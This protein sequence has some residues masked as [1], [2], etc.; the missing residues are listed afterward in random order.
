MCGIVGLAQGQGKV[1]VSLYEALLM[2]QHRGQDAAGM[3]TLKNGRFYERKKNGLVAD[4]FAERHFDKLK[5]ALGLGHVRYPT[6]GTESAR[7]AQPFFANA[8]FG[9]FL[10]HNGNLTNTDDLRTLA[11]L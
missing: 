2:L 4:V 8:P 6:A 3:V 11:R 7:E 10:V 9:I 1:A 5:G